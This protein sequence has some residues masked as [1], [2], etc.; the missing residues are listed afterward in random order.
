[1]NPVYKGL[2][3][4]DFLHLK[5]SFAVLAVIF[6]VM[7]FIV[8]F[9][10]GG[11]A[12]YVMLMVLAVKMVESTLIYDDTNQ[13]DS[14]VLTTPI[15][16]K[17]IVRSKYL[18]QILIIAAASLLASAAFLLM[19]Q[20]ISAITGDSWILAMLILGFG[21]AII[22]SSAIIPLYLKFGTEKARIISYAVLILVAAVYAVTAGALLFSGLPNS[23][24]CGTAA[25]SL[26]VFG[27]SYQV[28][29]RIYAKK[30]F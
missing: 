1:M 9:G 13:W 26:A 4:K 12:L 30:E 16:R 8:G 15:S 6:L 2:I 23:V 25:V 14:F 5:D 22:Y 19:T 21:Y 20:M 28:S 11:V 18:L 24:L 7:S 29:Q 10:G 17:A 3:Y 27:L